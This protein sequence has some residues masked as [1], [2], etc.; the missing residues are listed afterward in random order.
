MNHSRLIKDFLHK[1][2]MLRLGAGLRNGKI[3][4]ILR[5]HSITDHD[6]NYYCSPSIAL[7]PDVFEAHVKYLSSHFNIIS[8]DEVHDCLSKKEKFP[9]RAVVFTFDD[10][11]KDNFTAYE[12]LK[13]YHATGTFYIATGCIDNKEP[14]WLFE[15]IYL[16]HHTGQN[17]LCIN[18]GGVANRFPLLTPSDRWA[19]SGRVT[20]IIKSNNLEI[21]EQVR[22]QI[23]E[24]TRDVHDFSDKAAAVMLSTDQVKEM[25]DNGMTIAGHTV[26]HLNLP[27]ASPEDA[28]NEIAECKSAI[29]E[30]T[31]KEARHFSYPNGGKYA[32]YNSSIIQM[33]KDAGFLTATTSNN[34]TADIHSDPFQLSRIRITPYLSDILYQMCRE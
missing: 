4:S 30:M 27:N 23:R 9:D 17:E 6:D 10:G 21:R 3:V 11:Y 7:A 33:V 13:K 5:Y 12:I 20:E 8:L 34:G 19:A 29:F 32:Y 1:T 26:T 28:R 14:L 22:E 16:L 2:R 15:I 24:Q 18:V 31:G 25:S